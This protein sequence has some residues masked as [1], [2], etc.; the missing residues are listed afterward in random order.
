MDHLFANQQDNVQNLLSMQESIVKHTQSLID[1]QTQTL[2]NCVN[3]IYETNKNLLNSKNAQEGSNALG[4]LFSPMQQQVLDYN[5]Q[6]LEICNKVGQDI[7][8][9]TANLHNE[10]QKCVNNTV[11]T[12]SKNAPIGAEPFASYIKSAVSATS[13]VYEGMTKAA[14]QAVNVACNN[15]KAHSENIIVPDAG[16]EYTQA[17]QNSNSSNN[18]NSNSKK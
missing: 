13:K 5:K 15:A 4:Q 17:A 1:L 9:N 6:F 7:Q 10:Y 11:E 16:K 3:H 8:S 12:V 2:K 14:Q 18:P